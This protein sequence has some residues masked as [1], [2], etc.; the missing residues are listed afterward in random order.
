MERPL[1]A[2]FTNRYR[3]I[4]GVLLFVLLFVGVLFLSY[5]VPGQLSNPEVQSA[6][7]SATFS[8]SHPSTQAIIDLPYHLLQKASLHFFGLTDF[9]IILPSLILGLLAGLGILWLLQC[10]LR[11]TSI[12]LFASG[13]AVTSSQFI[14]VAAGGTPLIM[15]LFWL[16]ILL[17]L[18][19]KLSANNRSLL[20][21][22]GVGVTVGLSFYSPLTIYFLVSLLLAVILHPHLRYLLR[23]IPKKHIAYSLLVSLIILIP[24]IISLIKHP[25]IANT[26]AGWPGIAGGLGQLKFN[27]IELAK[28]YLL[29]WEPSLTVLGLTPFFGLGAFC[30]IIFGG[31]KLI[32]D[33]HAARSYSLAV[34]APVMVVPVILQPQYAIILFL[35]LIL[36]LAIGIEGLLDEWYKLFPHN[37]YAR[38]VALVPV[39]ILLMGIIVSNVNYFTGGYRYSTQLPYY[40]TQDLTLIRPLVQKYPDAL[41]VAPYNQQPFYNLLE[42]QYPRLQT[43]QSLGTLTPRRPIIITTG[44]GAETNNLG[45]IKV[46]VTDSY[47]YHQPRF[48][49]YIPR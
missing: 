22:L 19:L 44:T 12:A 18:A 14:F 39:I 3:Y 30:L 37:P 35:P 4:L 9:A 24:L 45:P 16:V 25:D 42:R 27:I 33:H 23:T 11:R 46:I 20:W 34:M 2:L 8:L 29:F 21:S 6:V 5:K 43:T 13:I 1:L 48:Y 36:L 10:W 47:R 7:Q 38:V 40:Y 26:L 49:V 31:L 32:V 15:P 17:L 28:G 41:I